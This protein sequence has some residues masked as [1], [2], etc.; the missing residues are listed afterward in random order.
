[1]ESIKKMQAF[2]E[3]PDIV[4]CIAHDPTL[5]QVLPF[6]NDDPTK[7]LND[8]Q[9]QGY[10]E[11]AKWGWLNELPRNNQQPGRPMLVKGVRRNGELVEDFTKLS[12]TT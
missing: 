6:L 7:D 11:K 4:V 9:T 8:W 10:K 1:M 2:D 5:L 12:P 3:S